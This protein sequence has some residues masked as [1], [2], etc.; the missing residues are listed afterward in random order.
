MLTLKGTSHARIRLDPPELGPMAVRIHT[1]GGETQIQFTVTN[2]IARDLVD[3]GM[4]RLRDMLEEH[5]FAKVDVDVNEYQQQKQGTEQND[6]DE[7]AD[8]EP[9]RYANENAT[10]G[11]KSR[12]IETYHDSIGIIDIFA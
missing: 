8:L 10:S 12:P 6:D 1:Q 9:G 3:S 11:A 5:G 4:Q 7:N 2:P